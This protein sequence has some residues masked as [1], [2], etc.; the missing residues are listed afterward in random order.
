MLRDSFPAVLALLGACAASGQPRSAS[1]SDALSI[2][3]SAEA[4]KK[5]PVL[6]VAIT[7]RSSAPI[8][9]PREALENPYSYEMDL[10]LRDRGGVRVGFRRSHPI[11]RVDG[12]V[13]VDPGATVSGR[14]RLA[15]RFR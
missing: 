5:A 12:V 10:N 11:P 14:Y 13:R 6:T 1:S 3:L 9:I 2:V 15:A 4:V 7:N 8:C